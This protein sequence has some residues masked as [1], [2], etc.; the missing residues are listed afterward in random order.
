MKKLILSLI[1]IVLLFAI[2][3]NA[4]PIPYPCDRYE[5]Q[6]VVQDILMEDIKWRHPDLRF[7]V[8]S[9]VT[10]SASRY[11]YY[12][13]DV[14]DKQ[15]KLVYS[16]HDHDFRFSMIER[17]RERYILDQIYSFNLGAIVPLMIR[18]TMDF[19]CLPLGFRIINPEDGLIEERWDGERWLKPYQRSQINFDIGYNPGS[20][21]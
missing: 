1:I 17:L 5:T 7:D 3:V 20:V 12:R 19:T 21:E 11:K 16:S 9:K 14:Y 4:A 6:M 15:N 8:I 18:N 2:P 13:V 10:A